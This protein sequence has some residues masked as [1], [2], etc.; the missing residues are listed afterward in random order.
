VASVVLGGFGTVLVVLSVMVLWPPIL[1]LGPLH[2]PLGEI[3][4]G[5]SEERG[6]AE[7]VVPPR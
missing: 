7:P 2:R 3:P 6:A 1:R 4:V 5:G